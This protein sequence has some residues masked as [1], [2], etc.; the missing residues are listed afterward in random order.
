MSTPTVKRLVIEERRAGRPDREEAL[1]AT[2]AE[3]VGL[4]IVRMTW[5][6]F[7]RRRV[8]PEP[9]DI[10]AGS[11]AFVRAA[12]QSLG[13]QL[14]H[15]NPYPEEL[16]G[17]LYRR[18]WKGGT[19]ADVLASGQ[20]VFIKPDRRWKRFTGFVVETPNPPELYGVARHETVWCS[21]PVSFRSE[22]RCY[23][24]RGEI[25]FVG[26]SDFGGNR[27]HSI[28]PNHD[29]MHRAVAA[30]RNAPSAYA[31]DFG[32]LSSGETALIEANDGFSVGAY[33]GV[34]AATYF[35]MVA[36]RWQELA[37]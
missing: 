28:E 36:T 5:K 32:V 10:V 1:L 19:V 31:I 17:F 3:S 9:G 26:F 18:V 22:W 12:L 7:L 2:H 23:V 27:L 37:G 8:Q 30:Y 25:R 6:P 16:T 21:E 13:K 11:V 33:D 34:P 35:D 24:V 4:P 29:E 15:P 20:R 14:P